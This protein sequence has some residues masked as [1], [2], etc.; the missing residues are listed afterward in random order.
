M[1]SVCI[2][3]SAGAPSGATQVRPRVVSSNAPIIETCGLSEACEILRVSPST[4]M[5]RARAGIVPG[6]RVGRQW[7]F[8]RDDLVQ[9]VRAHY[10]KPVCSIDTQTL[11]IGTSDFS[12]MD[13][14]SASHLAQQ[15]ARKLKNSKPKL[16]I[17]PGGKHDL[18]RSR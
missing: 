1:R 12:S 17:V 15:I 6:T 7:V 18:E 9:L 13:A 8:V 10:K 2:R 11:R 16:E 14:K 4:L 3:G 5:R